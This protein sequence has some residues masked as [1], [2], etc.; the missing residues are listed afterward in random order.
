MRKPRVRFCL[1]GSGHGHIMPMQ[2][3]YDVFVKKY[4]QV[5]GHKD[6]LFSR[7]SKIPT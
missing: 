5:R 3:I 4:G 1:C 6:I 7:I 2:A